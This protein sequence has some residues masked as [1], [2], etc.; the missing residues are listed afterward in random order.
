MTCD[1][2]CVQG[3]DGCNYFEY[4]LESSKLAQAVVSKFVDNGDRSE[5]KN[6]IFYNL[7]F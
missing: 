7:E 2:I 3:T 4:L 6:H 5:C 1:G